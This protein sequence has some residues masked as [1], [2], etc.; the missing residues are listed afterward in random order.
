[1]TDQLLTI[2]RAAE[3]VQCG[4]KT[5]R[6]ALDRGELAASHIGDPDARVKSW[7]IRRSDLDAWLERRSTRGRRDSGRADAI[8]PVRAAARASTPRRRAHGKLTVDPGMGR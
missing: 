6:R 1:M 2:D 5:I 3:I 8:E 4:T 7:R